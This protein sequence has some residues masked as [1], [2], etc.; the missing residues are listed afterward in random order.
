[1]NASG[2]HVGRRQAVFRRRADVTPVRPAQ[3]HPEEIRAGSLQRREHALTKIVE[4][5][6]RNVIE[7]RRFENVDTRV[8]ELRALGA[9]RRLLLKLDDPAAV[10]G[11]HHAVLIDFFGFDQADRRERT[12]FLVECDQRIEI[13]IGEIVAAHD[14]ERF[15]EERL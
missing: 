10:V 11:D 13:G 12:A 8:H 5:T 3:P 6:G 1:M 7:D 15:G 14:D 4:R 9:L 2:Q